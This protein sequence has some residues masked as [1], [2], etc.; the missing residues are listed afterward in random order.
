MT[1]LKPIYFLSASKT[2]SDS[3]EAFINKMYAF[4]SSYSHVNKFLRLG[5]ALTSTTTASLFHHPQKI[6]KQQLGL[7]TIPGFIIS[8][9]RFYDK[10][11][12]L[13]TLSKVEALKSSILPTLHYA[14]SSG[15]L[16]QYL[17]TLRLVNI[18]EALRPL[19]AVN[20]LARLI[21]CGHSFATQIKR[22]VHSFTPTRTEGFLFFRNLLNFYSAVFFFIT[23][24]LNLTTS[25]YWMLAVSSF[26]LFA[27]L[28]DSLLKFV[29]D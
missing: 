1:A 2:K 24:F 22:Q 4:K 20:G 27:T 10:I 12:G 17:H 15:T 11:S 9:R 26:L 28:V 23:F 6:V 21:L 29:L 25:P 5:E 8:S 18:S 14:Q 7:F 13:R 16:L 19:S 3:S